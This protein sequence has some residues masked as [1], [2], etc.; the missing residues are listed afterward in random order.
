MKLAILKEIVKER[1]L[2]VLAYSAGLL[3]VGAFAGFLF[4]AAL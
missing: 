4:G 1:P 3:A 2:S